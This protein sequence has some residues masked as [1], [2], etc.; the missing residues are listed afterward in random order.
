MARVTNTG[1]APLF[2]GTIQIPAHSTVDVPDDVLATAKQNKEVASLF[3]NGSLKM[4]EL[5]EQPKGVPTGTP[6]Q[7]HPNV[8]P[9]APSATSVKPADDEKEK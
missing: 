3:G 4:G 5:E 2:I 9:K 8:D 6:G 7:F 1:N